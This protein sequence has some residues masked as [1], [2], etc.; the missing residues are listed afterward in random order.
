MSRLPTTRLHAFAS[1]GAA[2]ALASG[3]VISA[4]PSAHASPATRSDDT[5]GVR[6]V[7]YTTLQHGSRIYLGGEFDFAGR[8]SGAG[9]VVDAADGRVLSPALRVVGQVNVA[10]PDGIGGWFIGG[11][12]TQVLGQQRLGL[13]RITKA[14][15]LSP[16]RADVA[17]TV[18]SLAYRSGTLFVGGGFSAVKGVTRSNVAA[19]TAGDST[20][21]AWNPATNGPVRAL[22]VSGPGTSVYLGGAFSQAAGAARSGAAEVGLSDGV[23]TAWNPNVTGAVNAI[24]TDGTSV[25]LGG[26]FSNAGAA[27]RTDL[28]AVTT[29][30]G[31]ATAWAPSTDG[32]V[33]ALALRTGDSRVFVGGSFNNAGGQARQN[34]AA[35]GSNG[36]ADAWTA[37]T[38]GEVYDLDTNASNDVVVS[39]AF[40]T[41]DG[42]G[43]LRG[44]SV[45]ATG[46]VLSWD[47]ATDD[48]IRAASVS[49]FQGIS[50]TLLGGSFSY[51]N[52]VANANIA[53][54]DVATG[55]V[56]RSF[57]ADTDAIVKALTISG[58]GSRLFVGGGFLNVNGAFRSRIASLD[59]ATGTLH[60]WSANAVGNVNG[61]AVNGDSLYVGGGFST[62]GGESISRLARVS[63]TTS[64]VDTSFNPSPGG[65]VRAVEVTNDGSKIFAV[66]GFTTVGGQ[67][68]PGAAL[69]NSNGSLGAWA[70]TDGGASIA[71]D[72]SPDQS[73]IYF[74][75]SKN[76]MFAYDY[77]TA[78]GNS[79][80]WISRTGG[81]VQA[82]AATSTEVYVGGHFRNF[83]E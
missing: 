20:V 76:R 43:R 49:T 14:G 72:L 70:P 71:A 12:F 45:S 81:D 8:W 35:I 26:D 58:D 2:M 65:V 73:R 15:K 28:A 44:A 83:P 55:D 52:G 1:V 60:N 41:I 16:F 80:T 48:T 54:L 22:E 7:V 9:Q 64:A 25:Y 39:G 77:A 33:N 23:A 69:V 59:P 27:P 36:L 51:V 6:G 50:R 42:V 57:D 66:G 13:A 53:A 32:V 56:I 5:A 63:V 75:T 67:Q 79:P 31:T 30:T 4:A 19:I 61:L 62:I 17:G 47:P 46:D 40:T 68:R 74:S 11:S 37:S 78:G 38:N 82:I 34:L 3:L 10:V 21:T 29:S 24:E 18:N